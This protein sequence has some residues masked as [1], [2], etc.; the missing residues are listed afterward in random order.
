MRKQ[1]Q[2]T[3]RG[4][5]TKI[6][7]LSDRR[8]FP[9]L[10]KI[11]LGVKAIS[12]KTG[13]EYP[14][15]TEYFVVPEEVAKV[16]GDKP[17]ELDVMFPVDD[18]ESVFP[19]ALKFYGKSRGLKCIGNG[20][21]ARWINE[22]GE[23]EE[24]DC[25]CENYGKGCLR[26]ANLLIILPKVNIGGVYQIDIGSY[27][28]IIDINSGLDYVKALIGRFAMVPLKL[29]RLPRETHGGGL[30]QTHY[31]LH[32][33]FEYDI[34]FVNTLRKTTKEVLVESSK[35]A[36]P[37]I[38][39]E[40]PTF[41][42][43]AEVVEVEEEKEDIEIK[44]LEDEIAALMMNDIFS[45]EER[46]KMKEELKI[47]RPIAT[48]KKWQKSLKKRIETRE[49]TLFE[50][51]KEFDKRYQQMTKKL[52]STKKCSEQMMKLFRE[53]GVGTIKEVEMDLEMYDRLLQ[54]MKEIIEAKDPETLPF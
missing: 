16:Y 31:T 3:F 45:D 22:E 20:V 29:K 23:M 39:D 37:P 24:R 8:R 43:G 40:S 41:D 50:K 26:R 47:K 52:G 19:Q 33:H 34:N 6:E 44:Q 53:F 27:H 14:K 30:K 5:F 17:T 42:E 28:S 15:E 25:P 4:E 32:V 36:L 13:A 21:T 46:D 54:R 12:K 49:D 10:G 9:R 11:R 48:L 35:T 18:K 7:G 1:E 51:Q 38:K 2:D